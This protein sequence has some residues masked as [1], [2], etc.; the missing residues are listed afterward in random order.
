MSSA[1]LANNVWA[2]QA[3]SLKT[4][5][6]ARNKSVVEKLQWKPPLQNPKEADGNAVMKLRGIIHLGKT[7]IPKGS[8][9][10]GEEV[11]DEGKWG[12]REGGHGRICKYCK[13]C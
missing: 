12:G 7:F 1:I 8:E 2:F 3:S 5:N 9:E 6:I 11:A 4:K 10:E 13:V